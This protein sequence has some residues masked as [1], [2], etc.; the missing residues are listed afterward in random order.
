MSTQLALPAPTDFI[1]VPRKTLR[2]WTADRQRRFIAALAATGSVAIAAQHVEMTR[3]GAYLLRAAKG[4]EGFAAAWDAAIR[5][6][7]RALKAVAFDRAINGEPLPIYYQGAQVGERRQF[8]NSLLL[9]LLTHYD[10]QP[11]GQPKSAAATDTTPKPS[12][13]AVAARLASKRKPIARM[14]ATDFHRNQQWIDL[15]VLDQQLNELSFVRQLRRWIAQGGLETIHAHLD[16]FERTAAK[17]PF[18]TPAMHAEL[19]ATGT[20]SRPWRAKLA[21]LEQLLNAESVE[22]SVAAGEIR[23]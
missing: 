23:P 2:G 3:E 15:S 22:A 16:Y 12:S 10:P 19:A 9:R 11:S 6:G 5:E 18:I 8:H 1:P 17:N 21:D 20:V 14:D 13:P 7:I 4:A